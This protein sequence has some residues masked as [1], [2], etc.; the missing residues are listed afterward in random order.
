MAQGTKTI[1]CSENFVGLVEKYREEYE[2]KYGI[3]LSET[4]ATEIIF[5]KI[6]SAGGLII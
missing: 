5:L 1:R 2:D 4:K 6:K 3:E